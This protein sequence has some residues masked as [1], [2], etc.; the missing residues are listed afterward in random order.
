MSLELRTTNRKSE[1]VVCFGLFLC[2]IDTNK[3]QQQPCPLISLSLTFYVCLS[4][5][6]SPPPPP[7]L[8]LLFSPSLAAFKRPSPSPVP[9]CRAHFLLLCVLLLW[10]QG[11]CSEASYSLDHIRQAC[12]R[13]GHSDMWETG[14]RVF[15]GYF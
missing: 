10:Y 8:D 11:V 5:T 1:S 2:F 7:P 3:E 6:S 13:L 9:S 15:W 14:G 4:P 12:R